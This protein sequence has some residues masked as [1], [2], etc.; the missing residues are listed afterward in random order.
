VGR[1][2]KVLHIHGILRVTAYIYDERTEKIFRSKDVIFDEN[3][4]IQAIAYADN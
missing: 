2:I 3:A 1:E 4:T